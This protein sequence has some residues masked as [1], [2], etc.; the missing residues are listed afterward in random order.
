MGTAQQGP[1]SGVLRDLAALI[2]SVAGES[3][4]MIKRSAPEQAATLKRQQEWN[5]YLEFVQVMFN[6]A[7]RLAAFHLPV[8]EQPR[9]MDELEAVVSRQ[10][11]DA[12]EPTLGSDSDDMAMAVTIGQT[13]ADSRA[14]YDR[15]RFTV[16]EDS[17]MKGELFKLF[18]ER[19][20]GAM[21][22]PGNG[23]VLSA[24]TLCASAVIP[25]MTAVFQKRTGGTA[26]EQRPA[27]QAPASKAGDAAPARSAGSEIKLVSVMSAVEGDE[28]ETRWGLHPRFRLDLRPEETKE[29][30]R[31]MNRVTRIL[32][33]RYAAVAFT[34]D[35]AIWHH[36][37]N[38]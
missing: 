9:F 3:V 10:L 22:C 13:V 8:R 28:V 12:L 38:A 24:A 34:E 2:V 20:A 1:F 4:S 33:E 19:V 36:T 15:F 37:G 21:G 25:A 30:S 16:T 11:K 26:T 35:W 27:E 14:R 5:I 32:G 17:P 6:L 7:D 23:M 29:L 31:L 18:A